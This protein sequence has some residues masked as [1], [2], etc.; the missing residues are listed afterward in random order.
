MHAY[1]ALALALVAPAFAI[2]RDRLGYEREIDTSYNQVPKLL[3]YVLNDQYLAA[4]K[5]RAN[6]IT[7][8]KPDDVVASDNVILESNVVTI[9]RPSKKQESEN[10]Q[11]LVRRRRG[12]NLENVRVPARYPYLPVPQYSRFRRWG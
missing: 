8:T 1:L 7:R 6:L 12:Y 11:E 4:Q 5:N 10:S 3:D 2:P 9:L